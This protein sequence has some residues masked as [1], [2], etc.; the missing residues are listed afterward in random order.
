MN[1]YSGV[2]T[3]SFFYAPFGSV[4]EV[5]TVSSPDGVSFVTR[6]V[7]AR[8]QTDFTRVSLNPGPW[9]ACPG[10]G[11]ANY[12]ILVQYRVSIHG[13]VNNQIFPVQKK[14]K[15]R[16]KKKKERKKEKKKFCLL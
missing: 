11:N 3:W 12:S 6:S 1:G 14:K 8:V 15:K 9:F 7:G 4:I 10:A 5:S 16:K 2:D 13:H